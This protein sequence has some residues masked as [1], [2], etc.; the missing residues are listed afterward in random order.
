TRTVNGNML[1][2][3]DFLTIEYNRII[4][5]QQVKIYLAEFRSTAE[6]KAERTRHRINR[7]I[8]GILDCIGEQRDQY[9]ISSR[10]AA[11]RMICSRQCEY[12]RLEEIVEEAQCIDRCKTCRVIKC[13]CP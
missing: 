4:S 6:D 9:D 7:I 1:V 11:W 8:L 2:N 12:N 3:D 5:R 10:T 13:S